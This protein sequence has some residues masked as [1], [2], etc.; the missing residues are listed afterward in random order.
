[1]EV[2]QFAPDS[3]DLSFDLSLAAVEG[4]QR[5]AHTRFNEPAPGS[6]DY[7]PGPTSKELGFHTTA[8]PTDAGAPLA[9]IVTSGSALDS[10]IL[11]H[12]SVAATTSFDTIDLS[13]WR[14][15]SVSLWMQ[16]RMTSYEDGDFLWIYVTDGNEIVSLYDETGV[17]NATDAL[18]RAGD[19]G[20]RYFTADVPDYWRQVQ[21]FIESSSNSSTGL[22]RYD[23][24]NIDFRGVYAVPEPGACWLAVVGMLC[25]SCRRHRR[26]QS[27]VPSPQPLPHSLPCSQQPIG[28]GVDVVFAGVPA[29]AQPDAAGAGRG[30]HSH[31]GQRAG[32]LCGAGMTRCPGRGAHAVGSPQQVAAGHAGKVHAQ[33]VGQPRGAV[34]VDR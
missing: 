30:V 14:S 28:G 21:L 12:R 22:E 31:R 25:L 5:I 9:G 11:S 19:Q 33:R 18:D 3:S 15:V 24:D 2:H 26:P 16:A 4:R 23:F 8:N 6:A 17:A 13:T 7:V 34:A 27:P 1:V 20:Y 32:E 10:P 29:D